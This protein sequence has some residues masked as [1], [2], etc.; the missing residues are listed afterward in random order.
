M[1]VLQW[2]DFVMAP[3]WLVIIYAGAWAVARTR[4]ADDPS[5]RFFF[6]GLTLKLMGGIMLGVIYQYYYT[7]GDTINYYLS[8]RTI[9]TALLDDF[10][11]GISLLFADFDNLD[12]ETNQIARK[13]FARGNPIPY[14]KDAYAYNVARIVF[15]SNLLAYNS[16]Y[17]SSL[18]LSTFSFIGVW[19]LYRVF[20]RRFPQ[21]TTQLGIA[22]FFVPSVFFWGSGILKDPITLAMLGLMTYAVDRLTRG[23]FRSLVFFGLLFFSAYLTYSI[24]PYI[25]LSYIPFL[26][27]WVGSEIKERVSDGLL[28]YTLTPIIIV[29]V[30]LS[31]LA[32]LNTIGVGSGRDSL[33]EILDAAVII[34]SDLNSSYYYTDEQG[35]SYNIGE[36]DASLASQLQLLPFAVTT[37]FFRPFLWEVRNTVMLLASLEATLL[38]IFAVAIILRAGLVNFFIVVFRHRFVFFSFGY[39]I[40]FAYMVGLT[41]GNFGNLERYKIPCIPFFI[42]SLFI[43]DY[44]VREN[45]A[46]HREAAFRSRAA[47]PA[48]IPR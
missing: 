3:L 21:L 9:T 1:E 20:W 43:I 22:F 46:Y 45:R 28:R 10:G 18:L 11:D 5:R 23:N 27:I 33:E 29:V 17:A 14:W 4:Y 30:V 8:A 12:Y 38:L 7:S 26:A 39:S 41:S 6:L 2:V 19:G 40:V 42:A 35:S 24:K 44:L 32:A 16:Y 36:F 31:G 34:K 15:F 48:A 13:Y 47:R 25:M 37:T